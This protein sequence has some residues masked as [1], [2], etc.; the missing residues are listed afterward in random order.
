MNMMNTDS[1]HT[2]QMKVGELKSSPTLQEIKKRAGEAFRIHGIP[3]YGTEDYQKTD[4]THFFDKTTECLDSPYDELVGDLE[5]PKGAY[6]ARLSILD[7]E[8]PDI[9]AKFAN[10]LKQDYKDGYA[11][12]NKLHAADML[13]IYLPKNCAVDK[14]LIFNFNDNRP[15]TLFIRNI[16][17][18]AE[19]FSQ[20]T[21]VF[22]DSSDEGKALHSLEIRTED[23]ANLKIYDNLTAS[24]RFERIGTFQA[25]LYDNS[26][27]TLGQHAFSAGLARNNFHIKLM[28]PNAEILLRGIG[29]ALKDRK[30]DN[31]TRIEHTTVNCHTDELFKYIVDESGYGVFAGRI[32]VEEGAAKTM[33]YQTNRNL[34]LSKNARMHSKPQLEIYADDVKCSHGMTTGQL[35]ETAIFYMQQRG[36]SYEEAKSMLTIAFAKEVI[37]FVESDE[38]K[39]E[40]MKHLENE[41]M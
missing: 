3:A 40:L 1:Y 23:S 7:A 10:V 27:V 12:L 32:F 4:L 13:C 18:I 8:K 25:E 28:K 15:S 35:D 22:N 16:S 14:P 20:A 29:L 21:I 36:I 30:I 34:L 5:L 37:D 11:D 31:Y 41:M 24:D 38:L 39:E 33:A 2:P 17:I 26:S 19:P 9:A 6:V